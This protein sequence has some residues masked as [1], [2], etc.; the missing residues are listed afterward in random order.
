MVIERHNRKDDDL[1]HLHWLFIGLL[2]ATSS[3]AADGQDPPRAN[4]DLLLKQETAPRLFGTGQ[5]GDLLEAHFATYWEF[6]PDS[7]AHYQETLA[8]VRPFAGEAT[9]LSI[10]AYRETPQSARRLR[11]DLLYLIGGLRTKEGASFVVSEV[12]KANLPERPDVVVDHQPTE[13]EEEIFV[14]SFGIVGLRRA[15]DSLDSPALQALRTIADTAKEPYIRTLA[16]RAASEVYESVHCPGLVC[17]G[18]DD[19]HKRVMSVGVEQ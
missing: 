10:S 2:G 19:Y 18:D 15:V 1:K 14:R 3:A 6:G 9:R 16:V 8:K 11:A 7:E 13:R 12:V 5:V 17:G 4:P